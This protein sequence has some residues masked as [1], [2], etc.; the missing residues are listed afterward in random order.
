MS[1]TS[2]NKGQPNLSSSNPSGR[3][4]R[5]NKSQRHSI[6]SGSFNLP[7]GWDMQVQFGS[8]PYMDT[9]GGHANDDIPLVDHDVMKMFQSK[10]M[11]QFQQAQRDNQRNNN[12]NRSSSSS[13]TDVF[14]MKDAEVMSFMMSMFGDMLTDSMA[15]ANKSKFGKKAVVK[16]KRKNLKTNANS[17][18]EN[19]T[20]IYSHRTR[21]SDSCKLPP[22]S[23][24]WPPGI[25]EA[26]AA[27]I[28]SVH[29][30]SWF[31][32]TDGWSDGGEEDEDHDDDSI[33]DLF[34]P[35]NETISKM[36]E[37]ERECQLRREREFQRNHEA[38]LKAAEELIRE[39]EEAKK[40][41]Q[42]ETTETSSKAAKK[43]EKKQ[44]KKARERKEAALKDAEAAIKLR[45]K[46]ISTWKS[47]I[48]TACSIG[49]VKKLES[50]ITNTP[51]QDKKGLEF[52]DEIMKAL[53]IDNVPRSFDEE[54][55]ETLK[56]LLVNC[57]CKTSMDKQ[58]STLCSEARFKLSSFITST[59]YAIVFE[60]AVLPNDL[61]GLSRSVLHHCSFLGD[62]PF[63]RAVLDQNAK[64]KENNGT[65]VNLNT[66]CNDFGWGPIHYATVGG[67]LELVDLLLNAGCDVQ[68]KTDPSLT[69]HSKTRNGC[70]AKQ[71]LECIISGNIS[72]DITSKDDLIRDMIDTKRS[73][74]NQYDEV[75]KQLVQR[76]SYV[77]THGYESLGKYDDLNKIQVDKKS[78]GM[79]TNQSYNS[80]VG[81]PNDDTSLAPTLSDMGFG[82]DLISAAL[83][84]NTGTR[85][86]LDDIVSWIFEKSSSVEENMKHSSS[87]AMNT[88]KK[89]TS[90]L[91]PVYVEAHTSKRNIVYQKETRIEQRDNQRS[92]KHEDRNHQEQLESSKNASNMEIRSCDD[93]NKILPIFPELHLSPHQSETTQQNPFLTETNF[94]QAN[95]LVF[96]SSDLQYPDANDT[97]VEYR[98][99][100]IRSTT[101]EFQPLVKP[102]MSFSRPQMAQHQNIANMSI[103]NT[104]I[105]HGWRENDFL[106]T[107][108]DL[109]RTETINAFPPHSEPGLQ[110]RLQQYISRSHPQASLE[111]DR[112]FSSTSFGDQE[113]PQPISSQAIT[114]NEVAPTYSTSSVYNFASTEFQRGGDQFD[115]SI[116][117]SRSEDQN[118]ERHLFGPPTSGSIW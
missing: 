54:V 111:S 104:S 69:C 39:E 68:L 89:E 34:P 114:M 79:K 82:N 55:T 44:R 98:V 96:S 25:K 109:S 74:M 21:T 14:P 58:K 50:L 95:E 108:D 7:P 67:H 103:D 75:L 3:K 36:Q 81:Q 23:M 19:D 49:D 102:S 97:E 90:N 110:S 10:L 80:T 51:F 38:S 43:R 47:R 37:R 105:H 118:K 63:I 29:G 76:L 84:A 112:G 66:L 53:T 26:A 107:S 117:Q 27:A 113:V 20:D 57:I 77:E 91:Q 40:K 73:E 87:N 2:N 70:T 24:D 88:L 35:T 71:L 99:D 115:Q 94:G 62:V 101:R 59:S 61:G 78:K 72:C 85:K 5:K 42:L 31:T 15:A 93:N 28:R 83:Q 64:I 4:M 60:P 92:W 86:N 106:T 52:D 48:V 41:A 1:H 116:F 56:W 16:I 46:S 17:D 65:S 100:S 32:G 18:S 8:E 13:R 9:A 12:N 30:N 33:P 45:E 22:P 6:P 11:K